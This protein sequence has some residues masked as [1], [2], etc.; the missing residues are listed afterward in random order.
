M[1]QLSEEIKF[2]VGRY[3]HYYEGINSKGNLY[4]ALNTFVIGGVITGFFSL[5]ANDD[6]CQILNVIFF[7]ELVI[8]LGSTLFTLSAVKP[9]FWKRKIRNTSS[10]YFFDDVAN[11]N[12]DD[13]KARCLNQSPEEFV[14][15]LIGQAHQLATGLKQKFF[16]IKIASRLIA[17]QAIAIVIFTVIYSLNY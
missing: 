17:L 1:N 10:I 2:I 14:D 9:F 4:L 15:D 11:L 12:L 5:R 6:L 16:R 7:V 8:C 13:Y 3:D